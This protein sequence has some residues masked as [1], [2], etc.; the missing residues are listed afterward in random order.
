MK[1]VFAYRNDGW[2]IYREETKGRE[3]NGGAAQLG[4]KGGHLHRKITRLVIA[5]FVSKTK[6]LFQNQF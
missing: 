2:F 4:Q 1:I 3:S 6:K 5:T